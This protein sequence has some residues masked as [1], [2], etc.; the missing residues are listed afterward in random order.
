MQHMPHHLSPTNDHGRFDEA[1][2]EASQVCPQQGQHTDEHLQG[3]TR[4]S[5]TNRAKSAK[6]SCLL[7]T[8]PTGRR[9]KLQSTLQRP[10]ATT[11]SVR[12]SVQQQ[13][14]S[15]VQQPNEQ[16]TRFCQRKYHQLDLTAILDDQQQH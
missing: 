11:T 7:L 3:Q 14:Q 4:P 8:E 6:I 13:L 10:T 12:F 15:H 1:Q 5:G 16:R 9:A 2:A